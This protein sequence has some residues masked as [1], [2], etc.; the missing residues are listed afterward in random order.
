MKAMVFAAGL[1][2]RLRPL[3]DNIPKA[4]VPVAGRPMIEYPLL[5]LRH[6]GIK[7]IIINLHH[8]GDKI[9]EHF[10]DGTTLGLK[11]SYSREER[12]LDT[13]GGLLRA[14]PF[15]DG[16]TFFVINSDV[17]ID[18]SLRDLLAYH[19]KK[20]ATATLVLRPDARAEQYGVIES[21]GDGRIHRFLSC[22]RLQPKPA[23]SNVRMFT[24][25]HVIE[26]KMFNYMDSQEPFGITRATYPKVLSSGAHLYGFTYEGFWQDL[27]TLERIREAEEKLQS[28]AVKL[29]Y[30]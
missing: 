14:R 15:L 26:P 20:K 7:E 17:L 1:G 13:G 16:E 8:C 9:A 27:G 30:L 10:G 5:L 6:Y 23:I 4:M 29:H 24:G 19:R 21:D 25:V 22:R 12:L 11:I 3:T 28:G 2:Q 18:V